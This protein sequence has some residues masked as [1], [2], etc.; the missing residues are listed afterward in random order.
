LAVAA[1]WCN[2]CCSSEPTLAE[3]HETLQSVEPRISLARIDS[4]QHEFINSYIKDAEA[5]PQVYAV[6]KG[7]FTRYNDVFEP[8]RMMVFLDRIISPYVLLETEEQV[9]DF[10]EGVEQKYLRVVAFL[11]DEDR[12][13][14]S[15]YD[16]FLKTADGL[17]TWLHSTTGLVT[18]QALIRS[19]RDKK[20]Y[21]PYLNTVVLSRR[22]GEFKVI[23]LAE[24]KANEMKTLVFRSGV[25]LVEPLNGYTFQVYKSIG[26]P[27]LIMFVDKDDIKT[28]DYLYTFEKVA[29][30]FEDSVKFVWMDG[31]DLSIKNRMKSLGLLE[32]KL[33]SIAFNLLE[34]RQLSFDQ[35]LPV[36][37]DNV[38]AFVQSYVEGKRDTL[39][40]K[41]SE[42]S[43]IERL[44]K[45][46]AQLT[47][48]EFESKVLS[49]GLDVCVL[50]YSS[51]DNKESL[52]M[53]PYFN[54]LAQRFAELEFPNIRVYRYDAGVQATP[55]YIRSDSFPT[56][57]FF[58]AFHKKP[59]F[60]IYSGQAKTLPMMFFIA[61]HADIEIELPE[62]PHL[63]PDQVDE[64]YRQKEQLS[65][66]RQ[67]AVAEANEKRHWEL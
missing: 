57:Y 10:F 11:Y 8:Y 3:L 12:D 36:T 29:E 46:T 15:Y 60:P 21:T 22:P 58:P 64:Y 61:N 50:F 16:Q 4:A 51:V 39:N 37:R 2:H 31:K 14:D 26:L 34:A 67:K 42:N 27:M 13:A 43:E 66:E 47:A 5:L 24:L 45:D 59:A 40:S 32:D 44:Y 28:Q 33:P 17:T 20:K 63:S 23:D 18:D 56:V 49:E 54:K 62:L 1:K 41:A 19:L 48:A 25:A 65:P 55:K 9:D 35:R 6:K 30:I 52:T 38:H 7:V 53:A